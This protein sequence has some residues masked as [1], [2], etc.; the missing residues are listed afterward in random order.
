MFKLGQRINFVV[1]LPI[2]E[3]G[4]CSGE[5]I[6]IY[7]P[8]DEHEGPSFLIGNVIEECED[9]VSRPMGNYRIDTEPDGSV[10]DGTILMSENW[11]PP[12]RLVA[13]AGG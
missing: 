12:R 9:G 8:R 6:K 11:K 7:P 2:G 10:D 5:V 1:N 4:S 3:S 13:T